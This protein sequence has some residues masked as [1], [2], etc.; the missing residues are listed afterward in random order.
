M[1]PARTSELDDPKSQFMAERLSCAPTNHRELA[2]L[3]D[4][5]QT[6]RQN[7]CGCIYYVVIYSSL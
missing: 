6:V 2:G 1:L 5:A 3:L 4:S 7:I